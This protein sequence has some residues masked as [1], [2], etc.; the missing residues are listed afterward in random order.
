MCVRRKVDIYDT[1][2]LTKQSYHFPTSEIFRIGDEIHIA[3]Y[4]S[5]V[6]NYLEYP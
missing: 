1:T 4:M 3:Q 2:K 5:M 6:L